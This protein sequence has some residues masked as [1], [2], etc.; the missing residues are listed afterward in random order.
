MLNL[1]IAQMSDRYANVQKDA[2]RSLLIDIAWIAAKVEHNSL[3]TSYFL[4][5]CIAT[6]L[7]HSNFIILLSIM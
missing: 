6:I 4:V 3:L 5:K 7:F 2:H 1:L